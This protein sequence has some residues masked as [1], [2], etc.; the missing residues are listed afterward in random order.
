MPGAVSGVWDVSGHNISPS[1]V[2]VNVI[3]NKQTGKQIICYFGR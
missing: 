1:E 3:L 2:D